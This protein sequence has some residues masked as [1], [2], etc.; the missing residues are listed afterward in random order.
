MYLVEY[1][2]WESGCFRGRFVAGRR[3]LLDVKKE[4]SLCITASCIGTTPPDLARLASYQFIECVVC[5]LCNYILICDYKDLTSILYLLT[6]ITQNRQLYLKTTVPTWPI[7]QWTTFHFVIL[8]V[9]MTLDIDLKLTHIL[10]I[11]ALW[12]KQFVEFR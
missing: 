10:C 12:P 8:G 4:P 3:D 6:I 9:C 2:V 1:C 7:N 5:L 11:I